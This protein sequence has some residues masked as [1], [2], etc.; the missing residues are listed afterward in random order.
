MEKNSFEVCHYTDKFPFLYDCGTKLLL[1]NNVGNFITLIQGHLLLN[2]LGYLGNT[3][4]LR[5][6]FQNYNLGII[7]D[8]LKKVGFLKTLALRVANAE[9]SCVLGLTAD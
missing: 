3:K 6:F 8:Q 9:R 5:R 1:L 2:L 4:C 7:H